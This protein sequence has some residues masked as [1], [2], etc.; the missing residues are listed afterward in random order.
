MGSSRLVGHIWCEL[1]DHVH[2]A[3]HTTGAL[4]HW[5]QPSA[6]CLIRF[7]DSIQQSL[8]S[9]PHALVVREHAAETFGAW[10]ACGAWAH[11]RTP[12][13]WPNVPSSV[14][15]TGYVFCGCNNFFWIQKIVLDIFGG[16]RGLINCVIVL[17]I[18]EG[19]KGLI[20]C[21]IVLDI[22]EG[23]K[24][25]GKGG[26]EWSATHK[27]NRKSCKKQQHM[28]SS[29]NSTNNKMPQNFQIN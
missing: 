21:V 20:H 13:L 24:K 2:D 9:V 12:S 19:Q 26:V 16:Q 10:C 29:T 22:L 25:G 3:Q 7:G 27:S 28:K 14:R 15:R 8:G 18:L 1:A 4:P 6:F 11:C 17:D 23:K 5:G